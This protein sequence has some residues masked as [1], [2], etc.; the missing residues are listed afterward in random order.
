MRTASRIAVTLL[1]AIWW[2]GFTFYAAVV[3]PT[4]QRVLGSATAQGFV[5]Q[6]VSNWIN[7]IGAVVIAGS[8]WNM[9]SARRN[10]SLPV[11]RALVISWAVLA[12]AEVVLVVLH[13]RIDAMLDTTTRSIAV[14][15]SV[16]YAMHRGYLLVATAQ[17]L[18]ATVHAVAV[19][20]AW[21][22]TD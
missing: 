2:G 18:A 22:R 10:A 6:P 13:P 3:V 11:R 9:V 4:G 19:G 8:C 15:R 1:F 5:T 7:I 21:S 16:F 12:I 14:D 20:Y 17:W